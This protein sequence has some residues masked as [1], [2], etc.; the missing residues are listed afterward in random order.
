[1]APNI[2]PQ[3]LWVGVSLEVN[4]SSASGNQEASLM[5]ALFFENKSCFAVFQWSYQAQEHK[6]IEFID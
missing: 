4:A 5:K 3:H 1:M 2:L 6:E